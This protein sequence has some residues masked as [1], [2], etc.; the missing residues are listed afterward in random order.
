MTW[1]GKGKVAVVGIGFSELSRH[2]EKTLGRLAFDA[3]N[4]AV[5]DAGLTSRDIDGLATYIMGGTGRDGVDS[6]SADYFMKHYPLSPS[7]EWYAELQQGM[8]ASGDQDAVN[9]IISGTANYVL[10]WRAMHNPPGRPYT[11]VTARQAQGDSQFTL[12]YG[13]AAIYQWHAL[14]YQR[15]LHLSGGDRESMAWL[16]VNQRRNANLN[17]RAHFR[18]TPMTEED[19]LNSRFIADPLCL[20]DCD[21]PIEGCAAF[22][23]TSADRARDLKQPPA[24]IAACAQNTATARPSNISYILDDYMTC[25]ATLAGRLWRD[26]GLGPRDMQAAQL[27]DGFSPST[28][29]WL[30]AAGFCPQGDAHRFVQDGRISLEGELPLNTFGGSLS[31]GRLHGMGHLAEAALQVTG[32]AGPRQIAGC[33]ASCA[34][35]GSPLL[36][37]SG[38]VF[39]SEP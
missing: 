18:D 31:E 21:I 25:G 1:E 8:I 20:F 34:I 10:V 32:R 14:A 13:L 16:A 39:T 4:A 7:F 2:S 33:S 28:Y 12:P 29:Y 36:R 23:L 19:Y 17:P 3:A 24:Y 22:V 9:A 6:V 15:Y 5:E 26:S 37:G 11:Q 27:Y 30:E 35:D 38:I